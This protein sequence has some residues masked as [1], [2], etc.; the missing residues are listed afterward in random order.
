MQARITQDDIR[1]GKAEDSCKAI[2]VLQRIAYRI[3]LLL[4]PMGVTI[5]VFSGTIVN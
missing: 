5:N 1:D 4:N 2:T 3:Y